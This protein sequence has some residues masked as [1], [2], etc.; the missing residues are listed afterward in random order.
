VYGLIVKMTILPG[1]RDELLALLAACSRDLPGCQTYLIAKD[2][3]DADVLWVTEA[4]QDQA[5]HDASLTLRAV[6]EAIP[7]IRPLVANLEKVAI[8]E[9]V[10]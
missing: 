3:A 1:R 5:A 2:V 8:T 7:R 6:Q 10:L 9:P 4:W